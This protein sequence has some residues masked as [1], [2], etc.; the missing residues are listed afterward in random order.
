MLGDLSPEA[1][2]TRPTSDARVYELRPSTGVANSHGF[3][4]VERAVAKRA[5]TY[6]IAVIGDSVTM[7]EGIP[8]DDLYTRV[9]ESLLNRGRVEPNVEVLNF[10]VPGYVPRQQLALLQSRILEFSPDLVLWQFHDNDGANPRLS[11]ETG[12][13]TTYYLRPRSR[14][15]WWVSM[16]VDRWNRAR[17]VD[18]ERLESVRTELVDQ[19]YRWDE[20]GETFEQV[21][22]VAASRQ[23]PVFVFLY[24]AWPGA[25][26]WESYSDRGFEIHDRLAQRFRSLGFNVL[27]L[28]PLLARENPSDLRA[29]VEDPWHPNAR[30]HRW[31]AEHLTAWLRRDGPPALRGTRDPALD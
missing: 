26:G 14:F 11:S 22:R 12:A 29:G 6:R 5:G 21:A 4:D 7:Q 20:V 9:L 15:L 30:G 16:R 31:I 24:P 17:F 1:L 27:D 13:W 10:G 25:M 2:L 19:L 18:R 3:R 28:L 8:L 23:I